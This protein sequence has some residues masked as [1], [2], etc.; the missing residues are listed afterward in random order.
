MKVVQA[1]NEYEG[2]VSNCH[3]TKHGAQAWSLR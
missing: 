2:E 1:L 3:F